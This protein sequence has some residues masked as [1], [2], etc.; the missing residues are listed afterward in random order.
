VGPA[1]TKFRKGA[2][3]NCGAITHTIK[4]CC[5]RPRQI[6]AKWTGKSIQADEVISNNLD[7]IVFDA[8][9]DRWNGY[10]ADSQFTEK[11]TIL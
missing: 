1:A 2:C 11:I 5:E 8:K 4:Y 7:N 3:T 6:G 10:E 9:R